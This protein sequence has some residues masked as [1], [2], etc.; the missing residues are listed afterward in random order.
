MR[1]RRR[2]LPS[3]KDE[4]AV[5]VQRAR[6]SPCS[7]CLPARH[8]RRHWDHVGLSVGDPEAEVERVVRVALDATAEEVRAAHAMPGR[9]CCVAHHPVYIEAPEAFVTVRG[10]DRTR[11]RVRRSS[12]RPG[13]GVSVL[14]FHTNL[15]RSHEARS[16][17][18]RRWG[19]DA[20]SSLEHADDA[21]AT[22]YGVL[23]DVECLALRDL[24][25]RA[26]A[27]FS[28]EPRVWGDPGHVVSRAAYMGGSLGHFGELAL[29]AHADAI[30]CGEAG[31]HVC[32]DLALRGV[33]VILLGHD[34]SEYPFCA[35]LANACAEAGVSTDEIVVS[36]FRRPWWTYMKG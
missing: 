12:R 27:K 32:Q 7:I 34:V 9:T 16:V 30:I 25:E 14:S 18:A 19:L 20:L 1:S 6:G 13:F 5:K 36:R 22:G 10:C 28:V 26:A 11:R 2:F 35:V 23:M 15:D 21:G 31:Y 8:R 17:I 33:D 24:V 4:P 29:A 3:W